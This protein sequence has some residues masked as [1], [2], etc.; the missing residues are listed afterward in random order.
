MIA[1]EAGSLASNSIMMLKNKFTAKKRQFCDKFCGLEIKSR[2]TNAVETETRSSKNGLKTGR[3][4]LTVNVSS[5]II[6]NFEMV[7][8]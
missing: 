4:Q 3:E 2:R 1:S 8:Y 7:K 6:C 5:V